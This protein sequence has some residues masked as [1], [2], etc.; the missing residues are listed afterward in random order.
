VIIRD[1][2]LVFCVNGASKPD[3]FLSSFGVE[4]QIF[5]LSLVTVLKTQLN[6]LLFKRLSRTVAHL[7]MVVDPHF[8]S[9][10]LSYFGIEDLT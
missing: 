6:H 8:L 5:F 1:E 4:T 2:W 10:F 7:F 3:G 9:F